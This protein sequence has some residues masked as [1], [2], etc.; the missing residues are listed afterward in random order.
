MP[1]S[2]AYNAPVCHSFFSAREM[3]VFF[4][5]STDRLLP[6]PNHTAPTFVTF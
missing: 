6:T 1:S 3:A 5:Q 2:I 4:S